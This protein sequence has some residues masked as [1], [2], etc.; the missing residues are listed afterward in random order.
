MAF[1]QVAHHTELVTYAAHFVFEKQAERFAQFQVH[2]IGKSAHVVVRFYHSSGD[3]KRLN[4]IGINSAL[5]QPF[6]VFYLMSLF[7]KYIDKAFADDFALF[8]GIGDSCQQLVEIFTGI[9]TDYIQPKVLVV[10]Q[11]VLEFIFPQQAMIHK[12][13]SEVFAD[14]FMQQQCSHRRINSS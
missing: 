13:A 11:Y 9:H 12:D 8:L 14:R 6:H 10:V 2:F 7:I 4:Y 1:Q 3:G 5:C